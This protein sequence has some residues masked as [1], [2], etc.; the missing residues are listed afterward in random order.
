MDVASR[1]LA[2][3]FVHAARLSPNPVLPPFLTNYQ[4]LALSLISPAPGPF[5]MPVPGYVLANGHPPTAE[6]FHVSER[7]LYS[8]IANFNDYVP[9][10]VV[11]DLACALAGTDTTHASNLAAFDGP[12]LGIGGELGFGPYLE[13]TANLT[14]STDIT[15]LIEP[16][17]GHIDHLISADHRQY[18]EEPIHQW[19]LDRL[20]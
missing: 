10:P 3:V 16:G 1:T 12:I 6:L 11:R 14:G 5:T 15:I 18:V 4:A 20:N 9:L 8:N 7:R 19:I 2:H 17:F 13:D